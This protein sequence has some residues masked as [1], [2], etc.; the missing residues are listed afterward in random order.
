MSL[1]YVII[2]LNHKTAPLSLRE[3]LSFPEEK[4]DL[5]LKNLVSYTGVSEGL[6]LSTCNRVEIYSAANSDGAGHIREFLSESRE[7]PLHLLEPHL[8]EYR[9][10][11]AVC[12]GFRVASSLDSMV[13]GES[14][15]TSQ[16]KK[17]FEKARMAETSGLMLNQF[18]NQALYISKKV[19]T[20]TAISEGAVSIGSV[21]VDLS[22]KIYGDLAKKKVALLGAGEMGEQVLISLQ[23][24]GAKD[25]VLVNRNIEKASM[26]IGDE[27]S[28]VHL[29]SVLDVLRQADLVVS[30]LG[31]SHPFLTY[32]MIL[33]IMG[34]RKN[35]PMFL[36]DLGVP[37]NI[38]ASVNDIENVYLYNIDDL[39]NLSKVNLDSR[40]Q[41]AGKAEE[42]IA[43]EA[44][45]FYKYIIHHQ[46][47][48]GSLTKKA[49]TIRLG[50]LEKTLKKL[51]HLNDEDKKAVE[52]CTEAI[53]TKLL[54][55]PILSLKIEDDEKHPEVLKKIFKL[56]S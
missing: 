50:E 27:G 52:K 48:I 30:S 53:V 6:I 56:N 43:K 42:M 2:G 4:L 35:R 10:Y 38:E 47:L 36:I 29:D 33:D 24:S 44:R 20:E 15:I 22:K 16:V 46:P 8:Y 26:L 21:A 31:V 45:E 51:S 41:E 32:K 18:I 34:D 12:H 39:Q 28:I 37:R 19:R 25:I 49:E 1:D 11:E 17:A 9:S 55:D 3:S 23:N 5:S 40:K 14:Q 54:H 7:I 13:V